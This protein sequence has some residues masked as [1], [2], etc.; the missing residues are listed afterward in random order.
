M[1][2]SAKWRRDSKRDA[3]KRGSVLSHQDWPPGWVVSTR[4]A[5][6]SERKLRPTGDETYRKADGH[7]WKPRWVLD[8]RTATKVAHTPVAEMLAVIRQ[9]A[10]VM[11]A[12]SRSGA[13]YDLLC[14]KDRVRVLDNPH[15]MTEGK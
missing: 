13:S 4:R 5:A 12:H 14:R 7:G 8:L 10:V 15:G 11:L 6:V 1:S 2:K 3:A 9:K